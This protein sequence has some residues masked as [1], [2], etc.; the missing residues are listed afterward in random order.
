MTLHQ[1]HG[2]TKKLSNNH[3]EAITQ[4]GYALAKSGQHEQARATLEELKQLSIK[5]YVPAYNFA[6]IYNGLGERNE[7]LK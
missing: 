6:M 4:L 5:K 1:K 3:P 7:A 2:R